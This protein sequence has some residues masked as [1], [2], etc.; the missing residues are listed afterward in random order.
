MSYT[1]VLCLLAWGALLMTGCAKSDH[2]DEIQ[3]GS[4][5]DTPVQPTDDEVMKK[6]KEI[7]GIS[8]VS[9]L[10]SASDPKDYGYIFYVEQ[11]KDH[12]NANA[13]TY[14]QRC[15]M[16]FKSYD[17]PVV[18]ETNGYAIPDALDEID[19]E[20][21]SVTYL[22][23]NYIEVEHRYFGQ[24]LPE[25]FEDTNF[26]Y[27]YTYQ[28]AADLHHLVTLLQKHLFPRTNKWVSTGVSK[29]GITSALYA[30]YSDKNGWN[31]ID[32][33]MPFCAPFLKGSTESCTDESVGSYL[34]NNCGKGFPEG[35]TEAKAYQ[36]LRALPAAITGHAPLRAACLRKFHQEE[37]DRYKDLLGYYDGEKLEKAAT[38]GVI[39]VF[40][41]HLL[42]YFQKVPFSSWAKYV[43]DPAK[44]TAPDADYVDFFNVT[45]F[46][47]MGDKE[48]EDRVSKDQKKAVATRSALDDSGI[49]LYRKADPSMPYYLQAYRE[50]GSYVL[51]YS[52]VDGTYL[53]KDFANEVSYLASA[54]CQFSKRYPGQWDG[55]KLMTDVHNWAA[56]TNSQPIAFVY[57]Y[58]DAWTGGAIENTANDPSRKV[59]VITNLIGIHLNEFLKE[60]RCDQKASKAIK[61]VIKSVLNIGE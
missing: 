16:T 6:L 24:S 21:D 35:S 25:P 33:F 44:A 4:K 45:D 17:S 60:D 53:T 10:Y 9:I 11:L 22:K 1:M 47:F 61:D 36:H 42:S 31:D 13:G 30:Y 46:I 37:T 8:D 59:W 2:M 7:P 58:H 14:K 38:A 55:G 50:L 48:L 19:N 28:A 52:L 29:S 20:Q 18:M 57:S 27:L 43:P 40:Y 26:T 32:L 3:M 51:D 12:N 39:G 56:T 5:P 34:I 49:L 15:F 23:A 41:N 54:D